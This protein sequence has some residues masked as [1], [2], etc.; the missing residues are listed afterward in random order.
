MRDIFNGLVLSFLRDNRYTNQE[1]LFVE[2]TN[3][4]FGD[5]FFQTALFKSI[6]EAGYKISIIT[7]RKH[8]QILKHNR[9][10]A[11][12]FFWDLTIIKKIFSKNYIVVGLVRSTIRETLLLLFSRNKIILDRDIDTWVK[13]FDE[14]SNTITWIKLFEKILGSDLHKPLPQIYFSEP[15][16][17]WIRE[18][19]SN[20]KIGVVYGVVDKTKRFSGISEIIERIPNNYKVF[21]LGN[22]ASYSGHREIID[23][24]NKTYRETILE[25]ATCS[26][27]IGTEGS[28]VHI[29]SILQVNLLVID[30][31]NAF[32]KN[33]HPEL[34]D[35]VQIFNKGN[36]IEDLINKL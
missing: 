21:L 3:Q 29:A 28:L 7:N 15:E 36:I 18:N 13:T 8:A 16:R 19:R 33:A 24:T 20:Y 35:N 25:I 5:L 23:L 9:D 30:E 11:N 34:I 10:V 27:I 17:C 2:P 26:H 4:G 31:R 1:I 6:N 22:R 32:R 12:I 14:N